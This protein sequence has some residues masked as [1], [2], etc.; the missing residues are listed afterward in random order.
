[1]WSLWNC[2]LKTEVNVPTAALL[3]LRLTTRTN[4]GRQK[5]EPAEGRTLITVVPSLFGAGLEVT[6]SYQP[7]PS[8]HYFWGA[9][10]LGSQIGFWWTDL[11][12][13]LIKLLP[14][15]QRLNR[16]SSLFADSLIVPD[17]DWKAATL[18][19]SR[20]PKQAAALSD[21]LLSP[22]LGGET[23]TVTF[24][25]EGSPPSYS[26]ALGASCEDDGCL[27]IS[28][29]PSQVHIWSQEAGYPRGDLQ[30]REWEKCH[31]L[32]FL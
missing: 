28:P 17:M 8:V 31:L 6:H 3:L 19:S 5:D 9:K 7:R 32:Y 1:M 20:E 18:L 24:S 10:L 27:L 2:L 21:L 11:C 13:Q 25:G 15:V 22:P 12:C 4:F 14:R 16:G 29:Q 23:K 26:M 30:L